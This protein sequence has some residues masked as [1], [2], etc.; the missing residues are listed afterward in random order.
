MVSRYRNDETYGSFTDYQPSGQVINVLLIG[1]SQCGKSAIVKLLADPTDS[2]ASTGFSDTKA[3]SCKRLSFTDSETNV[4]YQLNIIDT[5][6]LGE[7]Q[8]D[9]C[10]RSDEELLHAISAG[11][12]ASV[13][14][15][16][17]IC[18][19][20]IALRINAEDVL[21]IEKLQHA[22]GPEYSAI[23]MLVLT[24]CDEYD[25]QLIDSFVRRTENARAE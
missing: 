19:V 11:C 7:S 18:F 17:I 25:T 16:N 9:G 1:R 23:S 13:N 22:L 10:S 3:L 20:S 8:R 4:K 14:H 6:G 2:V 21:I 15:L 12:Q 5:A 24:H